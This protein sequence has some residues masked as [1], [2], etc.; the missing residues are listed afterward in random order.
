MKQIPNGF[1]RWCVAHP[2]VLGLATFAMATLAFLVLLMQRDPTVI[3]Y[4][5]F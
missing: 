1:D 2:A 5:G 4:E 3:L